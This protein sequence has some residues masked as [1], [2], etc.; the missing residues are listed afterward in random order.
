MAQ[1][2]SP[3]NAALALL[4]N[5]LATG[6]MLVVLITILSPVSGAHFNPI[7]SVILHV[8]TRTLGTL[9]A[10][11]CGAQILGGVLG[12]IVAHVMFDLPLVQISSMQRAT[13][14][15]WFAEAVATFGLVGTIIGTIR[16]QPTFVP[17]TVGL[18]IIAAYWFTAS[19]SF[20]NPAVTIARAMTDTF[21]GIAPA[22]VAGFIAAQ[23]MGAALAALVFGWLFRRD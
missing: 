18:Y 15:L 9:T 11:Y 3:T 21:A 16:A 13:S 12:T 6:A 23:S 4:C 1:R 19:T 7:V 5:A 17:V 10:L 8:R 20:A 22:H 14:G 2:L